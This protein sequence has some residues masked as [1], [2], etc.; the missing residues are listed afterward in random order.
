MEE[1]EDKMRENVEEQAVVREYLLG[2]LGDKAQMRQIE[3]KILLDDTFA[4]MVSIAEDNLI[5]DY[6]DGNLNADQR[7]RFFQFFLSTPGRKE[8]FRFTKNARKY[9]SDPKRNA[10]KKTASAPFFG[11]FF[12][13]PFRTAATF[14]TVL[15]LF[16]LAGA[17]FLLP[18]ETQNISRL[19]DG[20]YKTGRPVET[21]ISGLNYAPYPTSRGEGAPVVDKKE[22]DS[23][24]TLLANSFLNGETAENLQ[25]AG[26][27]YLVKGEFDEAIPQFEKAIKMTPGNARIYN[28]LG[29]AYLE[30]SK[31]SAGNKNVPDHDAQTVA[32]EQFSKAIELD[33]S[34]LEPRFNRAICYQ[35]M[36]LFGEAK[37]AWDEYL[38]HDPDSKWANEARQNLK[39]LSEPPQARSP[40]D[41]L[42]DFLEAYKKKDDEAAFQIVSKNREMISGKLIPQQL[43]FLFLTGEATKR[44]E[45][46]AALNYTGRLEKERSGDPY[47]FDIA[48]YYS[49]ASE[50]DRE[51]SAKANE[52]LN[53]GYGRCLAGDC[54]NALDSFDAA[55]EIFSQAGNSG[56]A[57]LCDY[58]AGYA[59]NRQGRLDESTRRLAELAEFGQDKG[60]KWLT[61]QALSNLAINMVASKNLSKALD[62]NRKALV[63]SAEVSDLYL[64]EK[65]STQIA[66]NYH[67]MGNYSQGVAHVYKALELAASPEAS[68]RQKFRDYDAAASVFFAMKDYNTAL[69]Y[70]RESLEM[71]SKTGDNSFFN[72]AYTGIGSIIGAQG[73]YQEAFDAFGKAM[74]IAEGFQMDALKNKTIA[75][76]K[77]QLAHVQRQAGKCGDA[78][79]NYGEAISFFDTDDYRAYSYDAHKGRLL[80]YEEKKDDV[81]FGA[82]LPTILDLFNEYREKITEE[83]NQNTFFDNE[84]D[85]YDIAIDHEFKDSNYEAAF[86][87]S[88]ES[89]ARTLLEL[90]KS[91]KNISQENAEIK[92]SRD[93]A[94]PLK[95]A[96]IQQRM[97]AGVQI[98]QYS[99]LADKTLAWIITKENF[100]VIKIDISAG[101]LHDKAAA[102][103]SSIV[104][105][106]DLSVQKS[107]EAAKELFR[108]LIAPIEAKLDANTE[109]CIIPDK[110]LFRLPFAAL[111]SPVDNT[112]FI[113]GHRFSI[114]PSAT[115]FLHCSERAQELG[116]KAEES[117]LIIGNPKFNKDD[118]PELA[119]L[120]DLTAA[121]T[122]AKDISQ[123]YLKKVVLA[124]PNASKKTVEEALP[125]ADVVHFAGHYLVNDGQPLLSGFVLTEGPDKSELKDMLL[126]N[127][128]I[129]GG[130][131]LNAKLVVLSA[132]QTGVERFYNG[133]GMIGSSRAF[134]AAGVPLVVASQWDVDSNASAELMIRFHRYRKQE[135][136][137]T[138][139]ALRRSQLDMLQGENILY[140][141]PYYWAGF[142][143]I[144][145]RAEF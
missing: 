65:V 119:K 11:S 144:G 67:H 72:I 116:R 12:S 16:V 38:K 103:L 60:Y 6:L 34:F 128:E 135:G 83:Q 108:L 85:V 117:L 62:Y 23:A 88:E 69:A 142:E 31:P 1:Q 126:A 30:K 17:Y 97:P 40:D 10:P 94:P 22:L 141:N 122:E 112:Y 130:N 68:Q 57:R 47:F 133:E 138:V 76:A 115:I 123:L 84:Q 7:S 104:L 91:R 5:E 90:Q 92:L 109:I 137:S 58:W 127:H 52:S 129:I 59:L 29:V 9:S 98:L 102:Y 3:E 93:V 43:A 105:N 21:R 44:K 56:E 45:Y 42:Q 82:E 26:R 114:A 64:T 145:G 132:C 25:N 131:L 99:V 113:S 107:R 77:L 50:E 46:L 8:H 71:A 87:Y 136:L 24:S 27:I 18:T 48:Q 63:L 118:F 106:D 139:E 55:H 86:N 41:V 49:S 32:L 143:A 70:Q 125:A 51:L 73:K 80:C 100:E 54:K 101:D 4:D 79:K 110:V 13:S 35:E 37:D 28:D 66:E 33:P 19:L 15:L 75:Y 124:S 74:E 89:R 78:E 120:K 121:E 96:E 53:E 39:P 14:A 134:L 111:V 20:A 95:L 61:A 81:S 140:R 2:I 36:K